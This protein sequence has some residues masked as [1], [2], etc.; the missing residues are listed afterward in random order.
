M[1]EDQAKRA[2]AKVAKATAAISTG[3]AGGEVL[4]RKFA[5]LL[6]TGMG[7]TWLHAEIK[8]GRF[9]KPVKIGA[10]AVAWRRSE[11]EAWLKSREVA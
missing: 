10:R 2:A 9:P 7:A 1:T 6:L 4:Y 8:A 3:S 5:V 11:I